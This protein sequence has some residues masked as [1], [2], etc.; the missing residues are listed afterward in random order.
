MQSADAVINGRAV[1]KE[2]HI[3]NWGLLVGNFPLSHPAKNLTKS[4]LIAF[5]LFLLSSQN[6]I[7]VLSPKPRLQMT[8]G[9]S[10]KSNLDSADEDLWPWK[11]LKRTAF[12]NAILKKR[13]QGQKSQGR[14]LNFEKGR[15]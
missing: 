11:T 2:A 3:S 12:L 4:D 13:G 14:S 8:S 5:Y 9:C 10:Q 1:L 7:T 15:V 6:A